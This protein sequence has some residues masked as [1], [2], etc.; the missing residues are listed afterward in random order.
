MGLTIAGALGLGYSNVFVTAPSAENLQT[1]F[2]FV[3]KGLNALKFAVSGVVVCCCCLLLLCGVVC[4]VVLWCVVVVC[5]VVWYV[6]CGVWCVVYCV[7]CVV[8]CD[9]W[10]CVLCVVVSYGMCG[11]SDEM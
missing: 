8:C 6:V 5:V 10:C 7:L 2:E 11:V 4:C 3:V 1:V 9:L